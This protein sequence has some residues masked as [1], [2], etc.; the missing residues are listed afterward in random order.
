MR[1]RTL[2]YAFTRK[3]ALFPMGIGMLCFFIKAP[4]LVSFILIG[5]G[6][7]NALRFISSYP[8]LERVLNLRDEKHRLGIH[9][10]LS[11]LERREIMLIDHYTQT[12][13][14]Q[15]GSPKLA[16]ELMQH[17]WKIILESG[18]KS[19]GKRLKTFRVSLPRLE[20]GERSPNLRQRVQEELELIRATQKEMS[21]L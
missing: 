20:G 16:Q 15:G 21:S 5:V 18:P 19:S 4:T 17:A 14:Q 11:S 9:W 10:R 2:A 13:V 8:N 3:A 6:L 7:I 12:L 1:G